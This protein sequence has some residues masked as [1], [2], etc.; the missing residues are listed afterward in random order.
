MAI[1]GGGML[2]GEGGNAVRSESTRINSYL[3]MS[4]RQGS[5]RLNQK[6]RMYL[7]FLAGEFLVF[8]SRTPGSGQGAQSFPVGRVPTPAA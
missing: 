7:H 5:A 8:E 2:V 1:P 4:T 3:K 6:G